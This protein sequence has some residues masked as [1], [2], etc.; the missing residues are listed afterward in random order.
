M[1]TGVDN[2]V[3]AARFDLYGLS[4][5]TLKAIWYQSSKGQTCRYRCSWRQSVE[6]DVTAIANMHISVL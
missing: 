1:G 2:W 4:N 6:S 3:F 5:V